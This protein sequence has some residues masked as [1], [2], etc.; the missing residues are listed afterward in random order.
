MSSTPGGKNVL[1]S[2]PERKNVL[3]PPNFILLTD[4]RYFA[5]NKFVRNLVHKKNISLI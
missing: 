2:T 1:I 5:K 4:M 3:I